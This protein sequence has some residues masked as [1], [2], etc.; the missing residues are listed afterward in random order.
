MPVEDKF[1][2]LFGLNYKINQLLI[3]DSLR[4]KTSVLM[5]GAAVCVH[6]SPMV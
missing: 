3:L 5:F 4:T 2:N 1:I 6:F